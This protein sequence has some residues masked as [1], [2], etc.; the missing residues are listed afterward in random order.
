Q[1]AETLAKKLM[2]GPLTL[3]VEKQYNV[4]NLLAEKTIALRISSNRIATELC[5]SLGNP[6]TATSANLHGRPN[7]YSGR[8]VIK[9]FGGRVHMIIDAGELPRNPPS[10][11]YDVANKRVLR[12][13]PITEQE[14]KQALG[15]QK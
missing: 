10:T 2:P 9:Q 15:E 13:G 1:D 7:I 5:K 8:E 6:I 4:P 3:V 14:I 11:M 12:F